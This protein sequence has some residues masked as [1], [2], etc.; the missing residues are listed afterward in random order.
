MTTEWIIAA[1]MGVAVGLVPG[2]VLY[3]RRAAAIARSESALQEARTRI[4]GL[5]AS[6]GNLR[7]QLQDAREQASELQRRVSGLS[8]DNARLEERLQGTTEKL[9]WLEQSREQMKKEFEQLSSRIFEER[10]QRLQEQ[11]RTGLDDL[12]RPFRQQLTDFRRRVDEIHTEE[13]K[14]S[15]SLTQQLQ[16]LQ[17]LNH[18]MVDDARNLTN[19]LKGQTK[20]QGNWGEMILER[21]LEESGLTRGREYETQVSLDSADGRRQPDVIVHLPDGKD[22]IIDA[23]VS[24]TAYERYCRED[25][26]EADRQRALDEHLVSLRNHVKE[27]SDKG[28]ETLEGVQTLDFVLLFVPVEGAFL[29]A[30]EKAPGLYTEAYNRHIV[31]VSPTTLLVTL[32]TINNIWR[33]EYQNRNALDIADRAGKIIDQVSLLSESFEDVGKRIRSAD[34]A[35]EKSYKQLASG[36]GNL[37]RQAHQLQEMGARARR[38]LPSLEERDDPEPVDEP[39]ADA[40]DD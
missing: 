32:R 14:T 10:S 19:A 23:K 8:T 12:L 22:V 16:Q 17:Q 37:L 25:E 34:K 35:W 4:S 36:R 39:S 9:Q 27:L 26:N 20:T 24:L 38:Q 6:D 33:N 1:L 7:V 40:D 3:W 31:L 29:T 28:Y 13:S 11:N 2:L 30:M 5:E 21:I 18:Q 15:A